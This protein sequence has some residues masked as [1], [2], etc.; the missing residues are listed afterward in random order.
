MITRDKLFPLLPPEVFPS[1][2]DYRAYRDRALALQ[3]SYA[4][5]ALA[6]EVEYRDT[7]TRAKL[8][9]DA[10]LDRLRAEFRRVERDARRGA[11]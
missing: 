9:R 1:V 8:A 11:E 2:T 5:S 3:E 7:L 10:E 4:A 6:A